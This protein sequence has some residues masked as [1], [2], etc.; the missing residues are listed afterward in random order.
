MIRNN[1]SISF[2]DFNLLLASNLLET[3]FQLRR[4]QALMN[5]LYQ[6]WMEEYQRITGSNLDCFYNNKVM[7]KTIEHLKSVWHKRDIEIGNRADFSHDR[8]KN[9]VHLQMSDD[10]TLRDFATFIYKSVNI[11]DLPQLVALLDSITAD[12]NLTVPLINH[13]EYL[14]N[15]NYSDNTKINKPFNLLNYE[16]Y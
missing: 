2:E 11:E 14:K 5:F 10:I 9:K 4:G 12:D 3:Q 8:S 16:G 1:D 7:P 13:F 15:K 6:Y